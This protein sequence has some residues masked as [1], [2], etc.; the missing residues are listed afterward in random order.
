MA[1]CSHQHRDQSLDGP[2]QDRH[3]L[4]PSIWVACHVSLHSSVLPSLALFLRLLIDLEKM[5][6]ELHA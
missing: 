4:G 3:D 1:K 5:E 6:R 2:N